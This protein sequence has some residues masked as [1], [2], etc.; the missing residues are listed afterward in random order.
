MGRTQNGTFLNNNN[1]EHSN[2][3]HSKENKANS[4]NKKMLFYIIIPFLCFLFLLSNIYLFYFQEPKIEYIQSS[5]ENTNSNETEIGGLNPIPN[6]ELSQIEKKIIFK[7]PIKGKKISE[8]VNLIF[9]NNPTEISKIYSFQK[10]N[11]QNNLFKSNEKDFKIENDTICIKD[12]ISK[13]PSY[14][15]PSN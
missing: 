11:Y 14:K 2:T 9:E 12:S 10:K 6:G 5:V 3:D 1:N 4:K 7:N 13:I 15:I 8:I